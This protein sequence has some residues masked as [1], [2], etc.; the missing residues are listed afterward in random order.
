MPLDMHIEIITREARGITAYIF[1]HGIAM[2]QSLFD[3]PIQCPDNG[4]VEGR[5]LPIDT[6]GKWLFGV[7]GYDGHV[8][9]N[10]NGGKVLLSFPSKSPLVVHDLVISIKNAVEALN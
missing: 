7:P 1:I 9:I 2:K 6:V 8:A 4:M 3:H 5:E 10:V